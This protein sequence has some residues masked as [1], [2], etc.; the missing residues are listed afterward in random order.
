MQKIQRVTAT[1]FVLRPDSHFFIDERSADKKVSREHIEFIGDGSM[2]DQEPRKIHEVAQDSISFSSLIERRHYFGELITHTLN[3]FGSQRS[4]LSKSERKKLALLLEQHSRPWQFRGV[5][6]SRAQLTDL[7][8]ARNNGRTIEFE[9]LGPYLADY[10]RY[11][12][13]MS[14]ENLIP[15]D[16]TGLAVATI[17]RQFFPAARLVALCDE[18]NTAKQTDAYTNVAAN[19]SSSDIK[20]FKESFTR[21]LVDAGVISKTDVADK[22]YLLISESTKARDAGMLVKLL[23]QKGLITE[24][25]AEIL[26]VNPAAENPLYREIRLRTKSG[27]WLCEAL[28]AASFLNPINRDILHLVVLPHYMKAQQ[29]KVWEILR[30]LGITPDGYHNIFY[31]PAIPAEDIADT[32]AMAFRRV[33]ATQ[34]N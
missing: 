23:K 17:M 21:L 24:H 31:N 10:I 30:V 27:R 15:E 20:N 7:V 3:S 14:Q 29:D 26:F 25:G 4:H 1:A 33:E 18:Y 11:K 32:I 5:D 22:D 16:R 34:A 28:D 13:V 2:Q 6:F 12:G 9:T 8:R 19:F